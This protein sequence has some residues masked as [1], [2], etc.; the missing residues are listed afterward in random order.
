MQATIVRFAPAWL[1]FL[2]VVNLY[3]L[4]QAGTSP[5]F[6]D[7]LAGLLALA[8]LVRW[9]QRGLP[10]AA[11]AAG[12]MVILLPLGW[13]GFAFLERDM[14]TLVQAAR[15]LLALP[16]AVA[17][18]VVLRDEDDRARFA[19]GLVLGCGVNALVVVMQAVGLDAPLRPLGISST[20]SDIATWVMQA[21][22]LPGLHRHY[23]ASS[24]VTSL[25]AP[26]ALYLY[27]SGRRGI[28]LP[29]VCLLALAVTLQITFTRSPLV[30]TAV[31]VAL[32]LITARRFG[33]LLRL[34]AVLLALSVPALIV[35]GPPGGKARWTDVVSFQANAS[36]RYESTING[37]ELALENPVGLGVSA[38]QEEMTQRGAI[39]ATH[40][41]LVQAAVFFGL[42]LALMLLAALLHHAWILLRGVD[43][44]GF[45]E[46]L[47]AVQVLGLFLF[48]EHLNN[49]TFVILASWLVVASADRLAR[50][51][52]AA[53]AP[54]VAR[55][56]APDPRITP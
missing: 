45:V 20:D 13:L 43:D 34:G 48:E 16:W 54:A 32:A 44:P 11:L 14:A 15:W 56:A 46:G 22:R 12:A 23:G 38:T 18:V 1:G 2:L 27:L 21:P 28:W 31:T 8:L 29:L 7:L 10:G 50:G 17:L 5:R 37:L 55:E 52:R 41:A 26:A 33:R 42:P 6:S 25:I 24:A 49:P 36:E 30:V 3:L 19:W 4:P 47:I 9:H 53:A 35:I 51:P 40:N 39:K